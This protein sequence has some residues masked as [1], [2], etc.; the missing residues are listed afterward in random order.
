MGAPDLLY[1]I[2]KTEKKK[3]TLYYYDPDLC[4]IGEVMDNPNNL[5]KDAPIFNDLEKAIIYLQ[6]KH[7]GCCFDFLDYSIETRIMDIEEKKA[8][9]FRKIER[10][11]NEVDSLDEKI[12]KLKQE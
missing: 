2:V 3:Y 8:D 5:I 11:T 12:K 6:N 1:L 4:D 10:L 9:L 7:G